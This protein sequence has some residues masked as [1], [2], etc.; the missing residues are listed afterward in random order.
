MANRNLFGA[1]PIQVPNRSGFDLS[2]ENMLTLKCGQLVPV[3]TDLLI[4][5]DRV[6][7]GSAFEIQLPPMATDFYGRVRFKMEAFFVPCRL[8]YGGWQKFMTSPTGNNAP[9]AIS[10]GSLLPFCVVPAENAL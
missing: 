2:H 4:P 8:L 5:G 6:S 9:S 10:V 7:V 1:T 3:M